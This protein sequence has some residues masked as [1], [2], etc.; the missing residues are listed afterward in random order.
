MIMCEKCDIKREIEK[1]K[2]KKKKIER[3]QPNNTHLLDH[4]QKR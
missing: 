3:D 2:R 1:K 4:I